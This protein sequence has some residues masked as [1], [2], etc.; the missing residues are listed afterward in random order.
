MSHTVIAIGLTGAVDTVSKNRD[1]L[2]AAG[3]SRIQEVTTREDMTPA[4]IHAAMYAQAKA[5]RHEHPQARLLVLKD[6]IIPSRTQTMP[7]GTLTINALGA[8]GEE[9]A[10][11]A[12]QEASA[13]SLESEPREPVHSHAA[14][15]LELA[16][17]RAARSFKV[18]QP[19]ATRGQERAARKD[20]KRAKERTAD[21]KPT[22]VLL[23]AKPVD[24]RGLNL[25]SSKAK[26]VHVLLAP[27]AVDAACLDDHGM[28][29]KKALG[30][31]QSQKGEKR[32]FM[33][34][35]NKEL[36]LSFWNKFDAAVG[37]EQQLTALLA[38]IQPNGVM[39]CGDIPREY[40]MSMHS[41][42]DSIAASADMRP[43][44]IAYNGEIATHEMSLAV[45]D[46]AKAITQSRGMA[47]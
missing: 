27:E 17:P 2:Q 41:I 33:K 5:L 47:A 30:Q 11:Q 1:A 10:A 26:L 29:D 19:V 32:P 31:L 15:V 13:L 25:S 45:N 21:E 28:F 3:V 35:A 36:G 9:R 46:A 4:E 24:V 16:E 37:N 14:N 43:K 8:I 42:T 38:S 23:H 39:V 18:S 6:R 22:I 20:A 12:V 7:D 44:I 34:W 40:D